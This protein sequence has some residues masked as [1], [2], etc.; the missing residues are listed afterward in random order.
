MKFSSA[1]SVSGIFFSH[2]DSAY[3]N[4]GKIGA[5]QVEDMVRRRGVAREEVER[6]L[7]PNL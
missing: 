1:A 4:V 2:P 3:F 7:A 5:D 6:A